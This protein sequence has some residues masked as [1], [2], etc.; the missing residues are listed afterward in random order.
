[1]AMRKPVFEEVGGFDEKNLAV[2]FNDVDLCIRIRKAGYRIIYAAYA[3][4]YH[5]E[6]KSRADDFAP[7]Q[8]TRFRGEVGYVTA[9]W[10]AELAADPFFNPNLSLKST[11]PDLAFPPRG[12]RP[13]KIDSETI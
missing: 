8:F 5:W 2:A 1:M 11:D 6:S 10:R 4:L 13:W 3:E 9:R 12:K 7:S